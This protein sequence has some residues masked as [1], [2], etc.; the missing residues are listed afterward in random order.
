[1][2]AQLQLQAHGLLDWTTLRE[3]LAGATCLWADVHGVRLGPAPECPP[4]F[5]HLWGWWPE[6]RWAR[7]RIDDGGGIL[8]VLTEEETGNGERLEVDD[9]WVDAWPPGMSHIGPLPA[10]VRG[11]D[12]NDARRRLRILS[13]AEPVP[14]R[15]LEIP[16]A[17]G[18]T[19]HES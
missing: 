14:L 15:F 9:E 4:A 11:D 7:V 13:T 16:A 3:R 10:I 6:A 2:R 17:T 19:T 18:M 8:A 5:T 12:E 1:M